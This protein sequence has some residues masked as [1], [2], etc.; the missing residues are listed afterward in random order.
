MQDRGDYN[1]HLKRHQLVGSVD[2]CFWRTKSQIASPFKFSRVAKNL[3][4]YVNSPYFFIRFFYKLYFQL[5]YSTFSSILSIFLSFLLLYHSDYSYLKSLPG[6]SNMW[7]TSGS[8]SIGCFSS[9]L[10]AN[11]SSFLVCLVIFDYMWMT[12]CRGSGLYLPRDS[13]PFPS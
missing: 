7:I 8:V 5:K 4:F 13:Q 3:D 10:S 11:F 6:N 1:Q 9:S 12:H 2:Y